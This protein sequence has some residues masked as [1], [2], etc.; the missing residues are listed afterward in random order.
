[1]NKKTYS[2]IVL[3]A[4]LAGV[5]VVFFTNWFKPK[6]MLIACSPRVLR[7][8]QNAATGTAPVRLYFSLGGNYYSLTDVK[9]V[10]LAKW[11]TDKLTQPVWHLVS[12]EGSDDVNM[13]FYGQRIQGMDAA[14]DGAR[15]EPLKPD[16]TYRIFIT[17]GKVKG[18]MDFKGPE[19]TGAGA[20]P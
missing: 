11:E 14:D 20:N 6:T 2:L 12:E 1:M 13:F 15:P 3:A 16:E 10:P 19:T 18:Q 8:A 9:V 4:V 7:T 17:A 5:Y